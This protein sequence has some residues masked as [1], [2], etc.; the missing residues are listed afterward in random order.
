[1]LLLEKKGQKSFWWWWQQ[2]QQLQQASTQKSFS[3]MQIKSSDAALALLLKLGIHLESWSLEKWRKS[4]WWKSIKD[5]AFEFS[6]VC[7]LLWRFS[8]MYVLLNFIRIWQNQRTICAEVSCNKLFRAACEAIFIHE[9]TKFP[10]ADC[11]QI[12]LFNY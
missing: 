11:L 1:M 4:Q 3:F 8:G 10:D 12:R 5:I 7:V 2:Q 6:L 9:S